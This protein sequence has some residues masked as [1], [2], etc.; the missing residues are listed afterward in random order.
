MLGYMEDGDGT[1]V[2]LRGREGVVGLPVLLSDEFDDLVGMTQAGGT[3][4]NLSVDLFPTAM[5]LSPP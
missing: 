3:A 4:L 1:E 2:G 5:N